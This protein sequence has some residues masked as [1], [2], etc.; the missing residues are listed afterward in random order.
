[1]P[2]QTKVMV[3]NVRTLVENHPILAN[4]VL[5]A[6]DQVAKDAE[7]ILTSKYDPDNCKKL[8]ELIKINQGLLQ[9]IGV[10]HS[11]INTICQIAEDKNVAAKLTG[12]GGGG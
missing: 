8:K 4:C 12:A 3:G 10:S 9:T 6:M 7:K 2:R 1:M 11:S 5:D